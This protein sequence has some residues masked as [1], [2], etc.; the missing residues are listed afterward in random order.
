MRKSILF[1]LSFSFYIS[2]VMAQDVEVPDYVLPLKIKPVVSGSFGEL[3]SNHFHSG[4]DLTTNGKTG[5]RV[6]ASDKGSVSRIK[7]SSAGYGK[8]LYIDHPATG[9]TTVYAHMERYSDKIDSIVKVRQYQEKSFEVELFFKQGELPIERG[10]VIGY[11]GNS[12]S[13][14]GP[15]LHYEIRDRASQKPMDAMLFR[16][17]IEDNVKPQIQGVKIY[18]LTAESSIKG[19]ADDYYSPTVKYDGKFHPKGWKQIKAYGKIGV[20]VQVLDYLSNS[21]RKCGVSSIELFAND[22]LVFHSLIHQFSFAETRY[23]NAQIDYA[24]KMKTGKRIQRSF[25]LPN[26][27]LSINKLAHAYSVDVKPGQTYNMKY[28]IKDVTGNT[29]ELSFTILGDDPSDF[30]EKVNDM[31]LLKYNQAYQIDTVGILL[32]IPSYALYDN[33]HLL[34]YK[35]DTVINSLLSPVYTIGDANVPVQKFMTFS[36]PVNDSLMYLKD[37]L[38]VAGVTATNKV[39]SR[40]GSFKDG[41]IT[42]S[43]RNFGRVGLAVDTIPPRVRLKKAPAGNIYKGRTSIEVLITDNFSGIKDYDCFIDGE[44]ALFEYDAKQSLLTGFFKNI[45]I[46]SGRHELLVKVSDAKNN[47]SEL[48]THFTL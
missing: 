27:R 36:I 26:N 20:G 42:T 32:N 16:K 12:G 2:H 45:P 10:E 21:W 1:L 43:T 4:L 18:A 17:D 44:W 24:E 7:V 19:K 28:V 22:T 11:S 41:Y 3:R 39:Y 33:Q 9:H 37:K 30:V 34:I 13:S 25:V 31:K 8:A 23:L 40:G 5:Y 46:K 14:G 15:H 48:K 38:C 35:Q 6:Y 47:Q 29:S